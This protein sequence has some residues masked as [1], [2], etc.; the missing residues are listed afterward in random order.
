MIKHFGLKRGGQIKV[1]L[2]D[3]REP[4]DLGYIHVT[5]P[6][7]CE[8]ILTEGEVDVLSLDHDLGLGDNKTGYSVLEWIEREIY[9]SGLV[10]PKLIIIHTG[11]PPARQRMIQA[12]E[13]IKRLLIERY[14]ISDHGIRGFEFN[15]KVLI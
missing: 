12:C 1:F 5:T 8:V 14:G 4:P 11:N 3:I 9:D 2:D 13:S 10:P 15:Y 7:E 6:H